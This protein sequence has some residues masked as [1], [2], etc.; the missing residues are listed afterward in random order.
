MRKGKP[1]NNDEHSLRGFKAWP[2]G[3]GEC[4]ARPRRYIDEDA[5]GRSTS[6][7]APPSSFLMSGSALAEQGAEAAAPAEAKQLGEA[8]HPS[9]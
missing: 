4:P 6:S 5:G 1:R 7:P 8:Q 3:V 2:T 9:P